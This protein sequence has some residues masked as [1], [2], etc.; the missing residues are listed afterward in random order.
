MIDGTR[1]NFHQ[2]NDDNRIVF[3]KSPD[4]GYTPS[5]KKGVNSNA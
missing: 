4:T 5:P 1:L 2:P 3:E